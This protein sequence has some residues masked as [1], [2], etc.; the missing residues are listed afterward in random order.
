MSWN[1]AAAL[2]PSQAQLRTASHGD[3]ALLC[4]LA[5]GETKVWGWGGLACHARVS[6]KGKFHHGISVLLPSPLL[7]VEITAGSFIAHPKMPFNGDALH[8]PTA[9]IHPGGISIPAGADHSHRSD[10][11]VQ[12][13]SF[14]TIPSTSLAA[15]WCRSSAA[16]WEVEAQGRQTVEVNM[17]L[18]HSWKVI[19]LP[20]QTSVH[21]PLV[22]A[23]FL[24]A[25][26]CAKQGDNPLGTQA[27]KQLPSEPTA[28]AEALKAWLFSNAG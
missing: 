25:K 16:D 17:A 9:T 8:H 23:R 1:T 19:S 13:S 26:R 18:H 5:I 6:T 11:K 7:R 2:P 12:M 20:K 15:R 3:E 10:A 4:V 24:E 27:P 14:C 22:G 28:K 21:S